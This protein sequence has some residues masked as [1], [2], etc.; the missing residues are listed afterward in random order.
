MH[1][2]PG[3]SSLYSSQ[4]SDVFA[5][6]IV[7]T[8]QPLATQ[9][10]I[11]MLQKGGNAVDAILASAITLTVVEPVSNGIGSDAFSV[12]WDGSKLHGFNGSGRSPMGWTPERF[13]GL[14]R[15][16]TLGWDCVT[17]P[18]AVDTCVQLS[19]RFGKIHFEQ[20]FKPAIRYASEGF[21]VSPIIANSWGSAVETYKAFPEFCR[22]L[23]PGGRA[24]LAG[25]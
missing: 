16:P 17:I 20:L 4:R 13:K 19:D 5:R 2:S 3:S 6:N 12:I 21:P 10:G 11:E 1:L 8:S 14:D 18:G 25:E 9:A 22:T 24:P 15:M 7:A 23:L